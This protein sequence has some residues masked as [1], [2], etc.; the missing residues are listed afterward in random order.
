MERR[1]EEVTRNVPMPPMDTAPAWLKD[2]LLKWRAE[3][4]ER[5]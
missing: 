1:A 4:E 3:E 5:A 2:A